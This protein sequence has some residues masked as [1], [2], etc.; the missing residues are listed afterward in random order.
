MVVVVAASISNKSGK[1]KVNENSRRKRL[2]PEHCI[3]KVRT[4]EQE[5]HNTNNT[6]K[7]PGIILPIH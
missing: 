5:Q 4:T 6:D 2:L 3:I 1:N 7:Y